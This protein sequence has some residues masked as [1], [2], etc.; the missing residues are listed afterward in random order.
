MLNSRPHEVS[1]APERLFLFIL[2]VVLCI[3]TAL[4]YASDFHR[5]AEP[6]R[7]KPFEFQPFTFQ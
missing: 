3:P 7:L 4:G 5:T 1:P 2:C 6:F